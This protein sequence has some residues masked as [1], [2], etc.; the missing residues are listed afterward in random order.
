[1]FSLNTQEAATGIVEIEGIKANTMKALI[2]YLH[3]ESVTN[4]DKIALEVFK[5]ADM[6]CIDGL[7]VSQL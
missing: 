4:L 2:E 3:T 6:Y 1:M 7:M 5:A